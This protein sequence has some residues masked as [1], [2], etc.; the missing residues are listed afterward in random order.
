MTS[1]RK[2]SEKL[3]IIPKDICDDFMIKIE[4][5]TEIEIN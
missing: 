5:L 2:Q 4:E 1:L 3:I